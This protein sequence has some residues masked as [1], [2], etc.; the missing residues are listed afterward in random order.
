VP[1]FGPDR[2]SPSAM[3]EVISD[4]LGRPVAYRRVSPADFGSTLSQRGASQDLVNDVIEAIAALNSGIYDA[5]QA[6]ATPGPTDFRTWCEEVLRP[7]VL[8]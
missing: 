5:D 7:A 8:A 4:V 3:A 1:V 6:A 2:L